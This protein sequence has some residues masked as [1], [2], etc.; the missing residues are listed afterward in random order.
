MERHYQ[1]CIVCYPRNGEI[2]FT[3][4]DDF[5]IEDIPEDAGIPWTSGDMR[6]RK[7]AVFIERFFNKTPCK[8]LAERYGVKENTIICMYRDAVAQLEHV[9]KALDARRE[10][11]KSVV[12]ADRFTDEQRF[13]LL[14]VFGYNAKE[15]AR[16]F[17]KDRNSVTMKIKRL[18]DR[19]GALF[20]GEGPKEEKQIWDP[21]MSEKLTRA[22]L[23]TLVEAYVEQGLSH[24]QA[25]GR[26]ADRQSEL[27][28]R[29]VK[30]RAVESRYYKATAGSTQPMR[31]V[32]EGHT[33]DE[34]VEMM[35]L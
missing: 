27:L 23:V 9:I 26:I 17:D 7:T 10:G 13:F 4:M 22:D 24:R 1:D 20:T 16:M 25:F 15:I 35:T 11:L 32:Y 19:Y 31:S 21:V 18:A 30:M 14:S 2:H 6:L 3:E 28:R 12:N 33:T 5:N 8:E 34:I 29:P